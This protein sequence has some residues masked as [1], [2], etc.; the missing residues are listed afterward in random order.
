MERAGIEMR[1]GNIVPRL[2]PFGIFATLDGYVALCA[3]S[4]AF[5]R[6]V[7]EALGRPELADD[8]RF[9]HAR[10]AGRERWRRCTADRARGR[11]S[12]RRPRPSRRSRRVAC[13]PP[14]SAN[15]RTPCAT[16]GSSG[17]ARRR[18]SRIRARA[19]RR[20]VRQRLP[21]PVL[22]GAARATSGPRPARRA[23]RFRARR[24][25]RLRRRPT[26]RPSRRRR[27]LT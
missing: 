23:Q 27:R 21:D 16:R 6:G 4:D 24:A 11:R 10:P 15:R 1:T 3:P 5:A 17:A 8:E 22:R 7:F 14:S 2:A 26:R 19:C 12:A 9:S 25:A 20:P 18:H 13:P